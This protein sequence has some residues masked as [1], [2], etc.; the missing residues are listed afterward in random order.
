[1]RVRACTFVCVF[2]C[3]A[4][5]CACVC[6]CAHVCIYACVYVCVC[7]YTLASVCVSVRRCMCT[8]AVV[9]V[10][11]MR[12][13]MCVC[14]C[15]R[16]C[17]RMCVYVVCMRVCMCVCA[18]VSVYAVYSFQGGMDRV[19]TLTITRSRP[20]RG[21]AFNLPS[22]GKRSP[23]LNSSFVSPITKPKNSNLFNCLSTFNR[24]VLSAGK[25]IG[26]EAEEHP[27]LR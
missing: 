16:V 23:A 10:V 1:M 6:A 9:Y 3:V 18:C 19:L 11:C 22:D 14:A 20:F 17:A 27:S 13:C 8:C 21:S 2:M 26:Q 12:V 24:N 15:V 7:R 5:V 4:V 25:W